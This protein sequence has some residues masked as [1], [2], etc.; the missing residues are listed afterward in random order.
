M[1]PSGIAPESACTR[2]ERSRRSSRQAWHWQPGIGSL[3]EAF[4]R[5]RVSVVS[6]LNATGAL[7]TMLLVRLFLGSGE[8]TGRRTLAAATLIVTGGGLIGAL[9]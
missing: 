9:H 7:W 1:P 2:R 6:P 5:G 3:L 4:S 8:R